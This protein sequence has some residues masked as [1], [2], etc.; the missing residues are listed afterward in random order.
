M[1][2]K[3]W[4]KHHQQQRH[5]QQQ[6]Q[7]RAQTTRLGPEYFHFILF[8]LCRL[9]ILTNFFVI[10]RLY[11]RSESTGRVWMGGGNKNGPKWRASG[12]I[13]P[14]V[15]GINV[16]IIYYYFYYYY[17]DTLRSWHAGQCPPHPPRLQ[18]RAG[19]GGSHSSHP[20]YPT[21][22]S[23]LA[24][25][26]REWVFHHPPSTP[27]ANE[28]QQHPTQ[29]NEGPQHPTQTH[30]DESTQPTPTKANSTQS[31]PTKAHSTQPRPT[32]TK[33]AQTMPDAS[34]GP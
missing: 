11:L 32:K 7:T 6:R 9:Y 26:S 2:Y 24:N 22:P 12:V 18:T 28:G 13:W 16:I 23:S 1:N 34:V 29:A 30:E 17:Y 10:F 15:L 3:Q 19:G 20:K 4:R 14:Q 8:F 33:K 31:R 25:T 21:P 27:K 5:Q